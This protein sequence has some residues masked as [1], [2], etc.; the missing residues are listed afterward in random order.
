MKRT[1]VL[2]SL[3]VVHVTQAQTPLEEARYLFEDRNYID[4]AA[5]FKAQ[6]EKIKKPEL[7]NE[8]YAQIGHC[9]FFGQNFTE[10]ENWYKKA[11]DGGYASPSFLLKYGD[12]RMYYGDY[13]DALRYFEKAKALDTGSVVLAEIR[14]KSAKSA[15]KRAEK[16]NIVLHKNLAV[17]NSDMGEY[18]IGLLNNSLIYSSSRME[19]TDKT[20]KT[21]WQGFARLYRATSEGQEWKPDGK[22]PETLN[23]A[24]NNG[25]FSYHAASNTAYY[26]QCNGF[27]GKGKTC[28]ILSTV[29]DVKEKTWSKPEPLTFNSESFNCSQPAISS[30]GKTLYFSSDKPG[31]Q[32]SKDIYR[33]VKG[34]GNL[35]TE[36]VNLGKEIN[37]PGDEVFPTLSGDSLLIYSTDSREG[38]GGLDFYMA[39]LVNG[40]PR[41]PRWMEM[42]FNS[43][44]D[45]FNLLFTT[46]K[47]EGFYCSNRPGGMGGDDIYSFIVDPRFKTLSG[48]VRDEKTGIPLVN[49]PVKIVGT[50]GS[51]FETVTDETG[52]FTVNGVNPEAAYDIRAREEGFFSNHSMV[53]AI[54]LRSEENPEVRLKE[55]NNALIN[56]VK[57]PK[58]EIKLENIYYAFDSAELTPESRKELMKLV[59]IMYENPELNILINSHTDE[60]GAEGYNYRLSDKR[61]KSVVDFL[62]ENGIDTKR[63]QSKGWGESNPVIPDADTDEEHAQNRRT[64]F[65]V[66]N[67][68]SE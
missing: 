19:A 45:D 14:I 64:T 37:G 60:Q 68:K 66:T 51:V 3:F 30:D 48:Y 54:D 17:L 52:R 16:P 65:Q 12:I 31:G 9:Y 58:G 4:A 13:D 1:L 25:T 46:S 44:G 35:W 22:L 50:D 53:G 18:G 11:Y 26:T 34:S 38:L 2:L 43:P 57:I 42:P 56:L 61:A 55:R 59:K 28:Q 24:Y 33:T 62:V 5:A 49:V 21:T 41:N 23:S 63:L 7:K 32:G 29:Y 6:V 20:D 40:K 67:L 15:K 47:L 10:A 27:D 8:L 39:E 36:P